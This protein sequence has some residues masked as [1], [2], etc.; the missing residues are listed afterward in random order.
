[1]AFRRA[2]YVSKSNAKMM[3][4]NLEMYAENQE[5]TTIKKGEEAQAKNVNKHIAD[6]PGRS[7]RTAMRRQCKPKGPVGI[8]LETL[9]LQSSAID[10]EKVI[11]QFDQPP[12]D[13]LNAPY[14]HITPMVR[15]AAARN[16]TARS[17]GIKS[18]MRGLKEIG[19]HATNGSTTKLEKVDRM[20]RDM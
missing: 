19:A 18:R 17:R 6:E 5:P 12:I 11:H 14:Q 2:Y 9:H 7:M 1:M 4:E 10:D 3:D 16:R 8:L 20:I 13:L 15:E